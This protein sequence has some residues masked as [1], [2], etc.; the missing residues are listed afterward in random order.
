MKKILGLLLLCSSLV[1][2]E[3]GAKEEMAAKRVHTHLLVND[4]MRAIEDASEML[5]LFPESKPLR[6]ALLRALCEK[7]DE[8][9]ALKQWKIL[10]HQD[11]TFF[12]DRN[13]LEILAWGVLSKAE[14]SNQLV[15]RLNSLIGAALTRD[16]KAIPLIIDQIRGSNGLLRTIAIQ[17][18]SELGDIPL[19][20]EMSRLL[21]EEKVWYARIEVI[22]A[23]GKLR[24]TKHRQDLLDIIG[25]SK[26]LVEEKVAA[27]VSFLSMYESIEDKELKA[28]IKSGRAG[29]RELAC[30]IVI[31]L[32]LQDQVHTLLPL[33]KDSHGDV[34]VAAINAFALLGTEKVGERTILQIIEPLLD[35][36][37][38]S[39][40]ITAAWLFLIHGEKRVEKKFTDWILQGEP[41]IAR[42]ASAALTV[43]GKEGVKLSKRLLKKVVDPYSKANLAL[44]L[45]GQ[46][47]H[48]AQAAQALYAVL[49]EE[50]Q[51]LWMWDKKGNPLFRSLSPSEVRHI[52][53]IPNYPSV[54]DQTTRLEILSVLTIL[55]YPKAQDAV[56]G[57]L[58]NQTWGASGAAAVTLLREGD[59]E[60]LELVSKLLDD[61]D[62]KL[63]IQAALIM[64]MFGSDLAAIKVLKEAYPTVDREMKVHILEA[65]GKIGGNE[66]IPFLLEI[67][68][69][70][71][72]VLRVVA[73]SALIQCIYH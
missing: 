64:A 38:H 42:M 36:P 60:A 22:K 24:M 73:A 68:N 1:A 54:V 67:L 58:Q 43:S 30:E 29:L 23:I 56:K 46:R 17:I 55:R 51:T 19:Q 11:A 50:K 65:L 63:R 34:R 59:E 7:G 27:I 6:L 39:V 28:L 8:M 61:P 41:K 45:I 12:T 4:P 40:A 26:T 66:S 16:A 47:K 31:H 15:I 13:S 52:E 2:T 10:S 33:L 44:G 53:Q 72:Q 49:T 5:L 21:K 48:T 62:Q 3:E 20:S 69:E 37:V 35:D 25:N 14:A 57:F 70:P 18:A 9:E 71:F 32:D